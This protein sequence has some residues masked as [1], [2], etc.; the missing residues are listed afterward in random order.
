M[1]VNAIA[2]SEAEVEAVRSPWHSGE[3]AL[4]KNAGAYERMNE[5]GKRVV[6]KLYV[7]RTSIGNSSRS[8]RSRYSAASMR[9]ATR[10][11]DARGQAQLCTRSTTRRST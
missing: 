7:C 2:Q 4:Q 9:T 11:D 10:G 6:R 1:N 3:I 8:Y 5:M